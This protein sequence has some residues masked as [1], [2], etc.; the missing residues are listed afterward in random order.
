VFPPPIGDGGGG[1]I[2]LDEAACWGEGGANS[3]H[4]HPAQPAKGGRAGRRAAAPCLGS[5]SGPI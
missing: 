2:G 4:S 5:V 1:G 3:L